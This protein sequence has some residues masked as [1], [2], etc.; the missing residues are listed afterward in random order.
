MAC[1]SVTQAPAEYWQSFD[2]IAVS[3]QEASRDRH[4]EVMAVLALREHEIDTPA[5][6][7]AMRSLVG[8]LARKTG[9][10]PRSILDAEFASAP[11]DDVWDAFGVPASDRL[12]DT[13]AEREAP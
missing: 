10:T 5:V 12:G 9:R 8:L 11:S 4:I 13:P 3:F 1:V 2:A 6:W 7:L